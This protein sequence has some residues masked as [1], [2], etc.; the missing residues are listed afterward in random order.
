[1]VVKLDPAAAEALTREVRACFN[2]LKAAADALHR[3]LGITAAMRA[4]IEALHEGGEQTV[5]AIARAK[6][7]TRQHIQVLVNDLVAAGLVATRANP[8]DGRS[9][10]VALTGGGRTTFARMRAREKEVFADLA[11]AL[12]SC[13]LDAA[14]ATLAAV[15]THLDGHLK[16]REGDTD[17]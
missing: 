15:R 4:V 7:V 5:P 8:A 9:P 2:R 11:R 16:E 3:G 14:V 1:M 12:G 6:G 17:A 13:D 10:L